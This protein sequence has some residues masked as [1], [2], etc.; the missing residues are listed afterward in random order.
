MSVGTRIFA[1]AGAQDWAT[2]AVVVA[3]VA[4]ALSAATFLVAGRRAR[5]DR[6]R[7]I[8]GEAFAAIIRYREYPLIV[9]RRNASDE[10]NERVRISGD[11]SSLQAE[12]NTLKARLRIEDQRVGAV[13]GDLVDATRRVAGP[14]IREAWNE[15]AVE[16]DSEMQALPI[17]LTPL[18]THD[19]YFLRT[20]RDH[21]AWVPARLI[22]VWR[23]FWN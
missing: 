1:E 4:A 15:A 2:P 11:L 17:D 16:A 3:V 9:R 23:R 21:L 22:R 5:L 12:L 18:I 13:F 19:D 7:Q 8:F 6:Q 20:V 10:A 14:Y